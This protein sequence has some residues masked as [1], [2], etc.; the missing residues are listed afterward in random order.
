VLM[1]MAWFDTTV[2]DDA[3][4]QAAQTFNSRPYALLGSL[5]MALIAGSGLLLALLAWRSRSV[6]VGVIYALVGAYFAFQLPIWMNLAWAASDGTP[7]A[8]PEPFLTVVDN[9]VPATS[10][11]LN[12][13]GIIGSGML[14]VGVAVIALWLRGRTASTVAR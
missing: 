9:L 2:I 10:G 6:L 3:A 7:A 13:V 8:L 14:V 1:V 11:Q 5:G 12:A 4:R